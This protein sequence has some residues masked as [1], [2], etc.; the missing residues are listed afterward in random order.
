MKE[1]R[2]MD[3]DRKLYTTGERQK[4]SSRRPDKLGEVIFSY[5]DGKHRKL[6]ANAGV[7]D[8][9]RE[10]LPEQFYDH[11]ELTS[12]E[13]GVLRLEVDPGSY[14]HELQVSSGMLLEQLQQRCPRAGIRRLLLRPRRRGGMAGN[15]QE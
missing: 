10:I 2:Q 7:V 14:M 3:E 8:I 13:R 12:I 9:W 5:L 1:V 11:C 6:E 15:E 4:R